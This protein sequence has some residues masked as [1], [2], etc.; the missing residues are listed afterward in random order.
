MSHDQPTCY[1]CGLPVRPPAYNPAV[2]ELCKFHWRTFRAVAPPHIINAYRRQLPK[3]DPRNY[4]H[5]MH[6]S[7]A[8]NDIQQFMRNIREGRQTL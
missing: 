2:P 7:E 8:L 6:L 4:V 5:K 3:A 1:F